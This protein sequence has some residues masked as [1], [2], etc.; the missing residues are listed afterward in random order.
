MRVSG[1]RNGSHILMMDTILFISF[2]F[3]S[4][5]GVLS[6]VIGSTFHGRIIQ[7]VSRCAFN[8]STVAVGASATVA[9][10]VRLVG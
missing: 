7:A 10:I 1:D 3:W 9:I 5:T 4:A 2:L 8:V 6:A